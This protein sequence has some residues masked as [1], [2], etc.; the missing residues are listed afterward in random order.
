VTFRTLQNSR[1]LLEA[2]WNCDQKTVAELLEA[3]HDK[4]G[5]RTYHSEAGLSYAV[6][7]AYYAA[8]DLYTILPELD[9]GKG[10]ADLVFIPLKPDIPAMLIELKYEKNAETAISRI[11]RQNYPD[12]LELYKGNL[13]LVGINYDRTVSN[14]SIEFKHHS[15]VIEKG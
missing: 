5:N 13:I 9:T 10:Y 2:T 4:A 3:A 6:Q 1:K 15:C 11:L 12:R 8:Q 14:D 7:L